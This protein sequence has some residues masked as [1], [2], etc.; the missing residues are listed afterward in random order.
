MGLTAFTSLTDLDISN[1]ACSEL[2]VNSPEYLTGFMG[3]AR[4][5]KMQR[6]NL[7]RTHVNAAGLSCIAV[8]MQVSHIHST[9]QPAQIAA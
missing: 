8:G 7:A 4:L 3:L 1:P 6:L 9:L 5:T 2:C